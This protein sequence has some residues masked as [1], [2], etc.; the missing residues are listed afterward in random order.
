MPVDK[1]ELGWKKW[2]E[3]DDIMRPYEPSDDTQPAA[4]AAP[5]ASE[6]ERLWQL[7]VLE[8]ER[9]QQKTEAR[10]RRR[11][12]PGISLRRKPGPAKADKKKRAASL[13]RIYRLRVAAQV[14]PWVAV[15][16]LAPFISG[17]GGFYLLVLCLAVPVTA[18]A[19]LLHPLGRRAW[20]LRALT[21]LLPV[22][23]W[24]ALR[25]FSWN[26][27]TA[28]ALV[29]LFALSGAVY[30][31]FAVRGKVSRKKKP[32]VEPTRNAQLELEV[33]RRRRRTRG[34]DEKHM[35]KEHV[36]RF[37]LFVTPLMCAA[38][39]A[40]ALLGLGMQ[41]RR[42]V[43]NVIVEDSLEALSLKDD[44]LMARRMSSAFEHLQPGPWSEMDRGE[45][46]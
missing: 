42:P 32:E 3:V 34:A 41:L 10:S 30:Y 21:P 14:A 1:N 17:P 33:R 20:V 28:L 45:K 8:E 15:L 23:A 22:E 37:L 5:M 24:F 2:E 16:L 19:L 44:M 26:P 43:P 12:W 25:Y 6:G 7:K 18:A 27:G 40:P 29:S 9:Q 11:I 4:P 39:L 35:D 46:L 36:R 13:A 31:V 38:L